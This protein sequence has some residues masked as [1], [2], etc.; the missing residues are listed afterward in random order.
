[1]TLVGLAIEEKLAMG[2]AIV[3]VISQEESFALEQRDSS[4]PLF[5]ALRAP[6]GMTP[7]GQSLVECQPFRV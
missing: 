7:P 4:T 6:L 1:G 2:Y 3:R 5:A